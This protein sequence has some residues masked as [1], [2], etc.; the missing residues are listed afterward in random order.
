MKRIFYE[1]FIE[2]FAFQ[3]F[4]VFMLSLLNYY[5]VDLIISLRV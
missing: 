5:K 2:L 4:I 3:S 1:V